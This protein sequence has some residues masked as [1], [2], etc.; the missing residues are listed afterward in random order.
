MAKQSGI[1]QIK[2]KIGEYSYYKQTGVSGGLI[3]GINQGLSAR[4]KADAAYAN[5]RL[6]NQ[7]FGAACNTASLLGQMVTPKFR[8]MILPFSQSKMAKEVLRLARENT[9]SWGQRTITNAQSAQLAEV[10]ASQSKRDIAEFASV[11]VTRSSSSVV[12]INISGSI[13]QATLLSSLGVDRALVSVK[14]FNVA[15]G[16]WNPLGGIMMTGY[17]EQKDSD[18]ADVSITAGSTFESDNDLDV[19]TFVPAAGH[20]G[21]Q[22]GV[23]VFMPIRTVNSVEHILQEYCSFTAFAIPSEE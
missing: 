20:A 3:R 23:V 18:S 19:D 1:H 11:V 4:V 13:E 22:L 6:N 8:P 21:H 15:T 7:E 16:Q 9:A 2:G 17:I 10:L 12:N 14:L 5:T